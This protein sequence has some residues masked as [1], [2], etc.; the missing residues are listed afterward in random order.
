[1]CT[2]I[3]IFIYITY[4]IYIIYIIDIVQYNYI[5][6]DINLLNAIISYGR[7]SRFGTPNSIGFLLTQGQHTQLFHKNAAYL[8]VFY[9]KTDEQ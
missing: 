6:L 9:L 8:L 4:H 5:Y 7:I 3:Y 2:Y 1:M